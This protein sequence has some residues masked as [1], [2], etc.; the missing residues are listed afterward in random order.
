MQPEI[1]VEKYKIFI[2]CHAL[3][4]I[5]VVSKYYERNV[6]NHGKCKTLWNQYI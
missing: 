4:N 2:S 6:V 5:F 1:L 3:Y